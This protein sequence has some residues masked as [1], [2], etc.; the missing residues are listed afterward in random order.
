VSHVP[1][2]ASSAD[3]FSSLVEVPVFLRSHSS[4]G[5]IAMADQSEAN[6]KEPYQKSLSTFL[7]DVP[8][9]GV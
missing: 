5:R 9:L 7:V 2:T 3:Y 1:Q 6:L 8:A 4:K